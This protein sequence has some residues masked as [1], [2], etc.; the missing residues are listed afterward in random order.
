MELTAAAENG[1]IWLRGRLLDDMGEV[2]TGKDVQLT[3]TTSAGVRVV[4]AR[5]TTDTDGRFSTFAPK[6]AADELRI[7]AEYGGDRLHDPLAVETLFDPRRSD[8]DL[9]VTVNGGPTMDLTAPLHTIEVVVRSGAE[10]EG[11]PLTI[12]NEVD[13]ELARAESNAAGR[14]TFAVQSAALGPP[15]PGRLKVRA[16]ATEQTQPA[17]TELPV[18]RRVATEL[19]LAIAQGVE[20]EEAVTRVSG[21]LMASGAPLE[22]KAVGL[23]AGT[24]HLGTTLTDAQGRFTFE[25]PLGR[26]G[27]APSHRKFEVVARFRSDMPGYPDTASNA[28]TISPPASRFSPRILWLLAPLAL[29]V[30]MLLSFRRSER[31]REATHDAAQANPISGI[32][33]APPRRG[34]AA[35]HEVRGRVLSAR[36]PSPLFGARV[37]LRTRDGALLQADTD[38]DGR[39]AWPHVASG[40]WR[41]EVE[42]PGHA[43]EHATLAVPHHGEWLETVVHLE[44][45]RDVAV[46]RFERWAA[47]WLPTRD[48]LLFHTNREAAMRWGDDTA[49]RA[50]AKVDDIY[51]GAREP[52]EDAVAAFTQTL[53]NE[54][55]E[56]DAKL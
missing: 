41:I 56:G 52:S 35:S 23:F 3:A 50:A 36:G 11:I 6:I 49:L 29:L 14:A 40:V 1:G 45:L 42:A 13:Q 9:E 46:A 53:P 16:S 26:S 2:L 5:L 17:Q 7:L 12:T 30:A 37:S 31:R 25:L 21:A 19:T 43:R 34:S 15:G 18:L 4:G 32:A 24:A 38:S 47:R 54:V 48:R 27:D 20:S 22:A 55:A 51:Y 44:H 28:V 39:F 8:V 10:V 33:W